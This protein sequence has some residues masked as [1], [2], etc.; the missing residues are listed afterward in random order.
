MASLIISTFLSLGVVCFGMRNLY[1]HSGQIKQHKA[2]IWF[3]VFGLT[4][5]LCGTANVWINIGKYMEAPWRMT[6]L[7]SHYTD[8]C[9]SWCQTI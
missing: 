2:M 6:E 3:Y 4:T 8:I 5:L 1:Y 7:G 9:M